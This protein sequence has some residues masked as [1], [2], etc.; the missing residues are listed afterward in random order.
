[1]MR[2]K[3]L[4]TPVL[5]FIFNRPDTTQ[6]VFDEIR[7]SRPGQLFV[8]ADGPREGKAGE[9][10]RCQAARDVVKQ[11]DWD[12][13]VHINFRDKNMGLKIA[14]SSGI[15]WFFNRVEEGIILE[16]DCVPSQSFFWFCQELLERYRDDERIMQIS[17]NNFLFGEKVT[18]AS[19]Y[20]SKLGDIWGWATWRRAWECYDLNMKTFPEFKEQGQLENYIADPEIRAWLMSYFEESYTA[21]GGQGLWSSQWAYAM[22]VQNS[23]AIVPSV[24][25]VVPIGFSAETIPKADSFR[26]Y[27]AVERHEITE[28]IHPHFVLPNKKADAL[29]FEVIRK[30]DPRLLYPTQYRMRNLGR[31]CLPKR[32]RGVI[33]ALVEHQ[34]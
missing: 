15:D 17:G 29:R 16:D 3:P 31:K 14:V 27:S 21:V 6:I 33:K 2:N 9:A 13:E 19:Y 34:H 4:T 26:L 30:T 18:D 5:F 28:I 7:K 25:L 32:Y 11:V 8:S 22:C 24:N 10:E 1:M 23:L 12:C 20:F